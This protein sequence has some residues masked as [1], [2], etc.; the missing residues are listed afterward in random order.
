MRAD[1]PDIA[2]LA[3]NKKIFEVLAR[4]PS[5]YTWADATAFVDIF[6]Q[7]A[8]E[9]VYAIASGEGG[10]IG[11]VGFHFD[12]DEAPEL[13]YWL[14]EPYWG[15]GYMSEATDALVRA[16]Q[17][18]RQF[19]RIKAQALT[20][21]AASRRILEKTGFTLVGERRETEGGHAG[22]MVAEYMLEDR[23]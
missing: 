13:G 4:L 18:T 12:S 1:V 22:Q 16:A 17:A 14:G 2:A 9:R 3:N 6:A 7:R 23:P 5:P 15:K 10:F 19:P 11:A 21:N 8:N 20:T